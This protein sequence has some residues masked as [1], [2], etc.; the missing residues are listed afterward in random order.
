MSGRTC[1]CFRTLVMPSR[2][3]IPFL[4]SCPRH[5]TMLE[6]SQDA[7]RNPVPLLPRG[8]IL[9]PSLKVVQGLADAAQV[10]GA[11]GLPLIRISTIVPSCF[12]LGAL[13]QFADQLRGR[14]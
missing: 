8:F 13:R 1:S 14:L 9:Q 3:E 5:H 2:S 7:V 10:F 4:W 12:T 11:Y 6:I